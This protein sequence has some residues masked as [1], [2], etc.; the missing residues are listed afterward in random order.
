MVLKL[1]VLCVFIID[2]FERWLRCKSDVE[3]IYASLDHACGRLQLNADLKREI[4]VDFIPTIGSAA[5]AIRSG[6]I[7]ITQSAYVVI[8]SYVGVRLACNDRTHSYRG[9]LNPKGREFLRIYDGCVD[10]LVKLRLFTDEDG[11]SHHD[12]IRDEIRK[13]G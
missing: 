12:G 6:Q 10:M 2:A 1:W 8:K 13:V 11:T 9:I 3:R 5:E 7:K 4:V